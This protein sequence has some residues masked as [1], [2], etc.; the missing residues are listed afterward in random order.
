LPKIMA[1]AALV[2][3]TGSIVRGRTLVRAGEVGRVVE[4]LRT[5][6]P[7]NWTLA[8]LVIRL[9]A[10]DPVAQTAL[11]ALKRMA[12]RIVGLLVDVLLDTD[13]DFTIRRR[14]PRVLAL[15][16]SSRAA[17]TPHRGTTRYRGIATPC[18]AY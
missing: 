16:P 17:L 18:D 15:V 3:I 6:G 14:V 9:L 4:A 7:E 8:P 12:P 10:W 11:D 1:A 5:L 2:A 13:R